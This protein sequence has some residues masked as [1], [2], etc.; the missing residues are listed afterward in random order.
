MNAKSSPM[1]LFEFFVMHGNVLISMVYNVVNHC[2]SMGNIYVK[3]EHR[4]DANQAFCL[5]I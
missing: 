5:R 1:P 2:L 3:V 4:W